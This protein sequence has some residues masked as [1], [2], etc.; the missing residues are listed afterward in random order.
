[1]KPHLLASLGEVHDMIRFGQR[2]RIDKSKTDL[3]HSVFSLSMCVLRKSTQNRLA[4]YLFSSFSVCDISDTKGG[5]LKMEA[6]TFK[7]KTPQITGGRSHI[8]LASTE[9]MSVGLNYYI[10]GRKNKLHTHPGEDHIFVVMDGRATFYNKE[11]QPIVLNKGEGIMLPE[12][13]YYYFQSTGDKPLALFRVSAKKDNKPKVVRVDAEGN[14]RT[15]EEN[16]FVVVDGAAIEGKFWEL[17]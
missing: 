14:K 11:H 13:H 8:P 16:E 6:S 1:M 17:T 12:N 4:F 2:S 5:Q 10:P 7:L 9:H 15:E 3:S